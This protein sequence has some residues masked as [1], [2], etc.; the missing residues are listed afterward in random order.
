MTAAEIRAKTIVMADKICLI[1]DL[2][3]HGFM[4]NKLEP[5]ENAM[6]EEHMINETEKAVTEDIFAISKATKDKAIKKELSVT[7]QTAETLERMGDEAA[8]MIERIE[9]KVAEHLLFSEIGVQQFNETFNVM[10]ES[11][12]MMRQCL[13]EPSAELKN[14]IVDNGFKVKGLVEH[15]RKEHLERLVQGLCTPMGANMYF[16]MLDFTGNL[17]RH[18]SNIAKLY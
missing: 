11:V 16:D 18:A 5:L 13:T 7:I 1:L 12:R 3:E 17:A 9:I 10:K 15:Y 2:I 4:E 14:K 6:K 8:N